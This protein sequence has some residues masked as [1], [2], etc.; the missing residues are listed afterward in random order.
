[1]AQSDSGLPGAKVGFTGGE[2]KYRSVLGDK[3]PKL[4]ATAL[5]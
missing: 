5:Y 4:K 3:K 2:G 1:M